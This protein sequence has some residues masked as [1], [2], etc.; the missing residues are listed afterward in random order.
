MSEYSAMF[1]QQI[2]QE[3]L[4]H[5]QA[6]RYVEEAWRRDNTQIIMWKKMFLIGLKN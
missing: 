1:S 6:A 4:T 5:V 2:I 3:A